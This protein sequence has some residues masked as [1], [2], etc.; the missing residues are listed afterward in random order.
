MSRC[1]A[2]AVRRHPKVKDIEALACGRRSPYALYE[3]NVK[4][5][6]VRCREEGGGEEMV[7]HLP[8]IFKDSVSAEALSR[9][10]REEEASQQV[11]GVWL[12]RRKVSW[13]LL[14]Q[15]I[16]GTRIRLLRANYDEMGC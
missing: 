9:R 5:L 15:E 16:Q 11:L 2:E 13:L 4:E 10:M 7:D 3:N 14:E 6:R 8:G 12:R 1:Q